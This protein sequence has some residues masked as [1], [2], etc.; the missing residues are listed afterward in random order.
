MIKNEQELYE[1]LGDFDKFQK[2]TKDFE[3]K[4]LRRVMITVPPLV[5]HHIKNEHTYNKIKD[6]FFLANPELVDHKQSF[7]QQLNIVASEHTDWTIQQV[8]DQA[9]IETKKILRG[10]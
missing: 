6:E 5:I 10:S 7:A 1:M 3:E 9:G 4:I 8:F 2:F